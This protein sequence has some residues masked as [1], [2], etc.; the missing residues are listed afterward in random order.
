MFGRGKGLGKREDGRVDIIK[1]A[2]KNDQSG[3]GVGSD[4]WS[5]NWWDHA[6]NKASSN[7][8]I[9]TTGDVQKLSNLMIFMMMC[10][11]CCRI[12]KA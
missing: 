2:M 3:I 4:Q 8:N 11:G 7:I 10:V 5:F 9:E 12:H 6:F 1:V